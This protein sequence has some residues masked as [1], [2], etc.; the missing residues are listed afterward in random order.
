MYYHLKIIMSLN[1]FSDLFLKLDSSNSIN[2]KI[3]FLKKY[4]YLITL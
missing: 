2:N 3:E 4:F 1:N